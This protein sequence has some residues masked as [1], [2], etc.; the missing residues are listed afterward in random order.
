M[1][2]Q[3]RTNRAD[4]EKTIE[5]GIGSGSELSATGPAIFSSYQQAHAHIVI[6]I[7]CLYKFDP[8]KP[9]FYIVK[10]GFTGVYVIS[11]ISYSYF[12]F[13]P[14][15]HNLC[16]FCFFLFFFFGG[17]SFSIFE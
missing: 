14:S 12:L 13:S 2:N 9:H 16:V 11:L 8:L 3:A 7:T 17:K 10:L 1:D 4:Q 6:T 15:T 5:N